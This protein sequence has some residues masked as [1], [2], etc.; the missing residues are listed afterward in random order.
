M[1][2]IFLIVLLGIDVLTFAILSILSQFIVKVNTTT[3]EMCDGFGRVIMP[4]P[5]LVGGGEW[6][7]LKWFV[8]DTAVALLLIG[9]AICLYQIIMEMPRASNKKEL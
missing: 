4:A 6:V 3:G 1:K 5:M 9:I 8:I 2:R 7:G